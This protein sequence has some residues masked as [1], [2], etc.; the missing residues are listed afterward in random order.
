[1]DQILY[2]IGFGDAVCTGKHSSLTNGDLGSFNLWMSNNDQIKT[3][4][5][6]GLG[7]S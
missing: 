2:Q 7:S 1:L 5:D 6:N 3:L 4:G